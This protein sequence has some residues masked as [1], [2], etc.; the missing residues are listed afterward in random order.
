MANRQFLTGFTHTLQFNFYD[1][2]GNPIGVNSPE[3]RIYTPDKAI[4]LEGQS[5]SLLA[6]TCNSYTFDFFAT[7]GLTVGQWFAIGTGLTTPA[8]SMVLSDQYPFEIVDLTKEPFWVSLDE[9]YTYLEVDPIDHSRDRHFKQLLQTSMQLI[10]DYTQ[11]KFGTQI[12]NQTI[13]L[14]HATR[15]KLNCFPVQSIVALTVQARIIPRQLDNL[16]S[17]TFTGS[18][19]SF[20]FRLDA[21]AG[22]IILT[23]ENG[24]E[25]PRDDLI[26]TTTYRAGFPSIPEPVRTAALQLTSQLDNL[27]CNEGYDTVRLTDMSFTPTKSLFKGVI[28]DM[29]RHYRN[30]GFW[31]SSLANAD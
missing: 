5:L 23:D 3:T 24:Y 22:I 27:V 25:I 2:T 18:Q 11:R 28:G 17:Q 12:V 13:E 6:G 14:Q 30:V 15:V 19:V 10:E 29:L 8:N 16:F 9:F 7:A 1:E 4:F 31:N 21:G 20:F 26:L